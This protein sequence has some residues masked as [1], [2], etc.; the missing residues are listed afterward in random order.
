MMRQGSR[1]ASHDHTEPVAVG[2]VLVETATEAM[3]IQSVLQPQAL[4]ILA[5]LAQHTRLEAFRILSV[6]GPSGM[7]AGSIAKTLATPHNTLSTHLAILQRA[8]L[9]RS[10]KQGRNVTYFIVP[11]SLGALIFFLQQDCCG[12]MPAQCS[13]DFFQPADRASPA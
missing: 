4:A 9:I 13:S 2:S 10:T 3:P 12:A 1:A 7:G 6:A 5:A 8:G 11:E